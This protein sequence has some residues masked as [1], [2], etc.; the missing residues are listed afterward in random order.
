MGHILDSFG[1]NIFTKLIFLA[2]AT[3]STTSLEEGS[4]DRYTSNLIYVKKGQ[5]LAV[6]PEWGPN[7]RITFDLNVHSLYSSRSDG[8]ANVLYFTAS[9]KDCC[10]IGDRVPGLWTNSKGN[11]LYFCNNVDHN[12]DYCRTT[13]AGA[14]RTNTWC[15]K[16][17]KDTSGGTLSK[18]QE[19]E[20]WP[21]SLI[22]NPEN[23]TML[24]F[25]QIALFI[26]LRMPKSEI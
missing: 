22:Q 19:L 26:L 15:N 10:S 6:I 25:M 24:L 20:Q 5:L 16:S 3:F 11:Y 9:G 14:F 12:G 1:M 13:A 18:L 8:W 21:M 17:L 4:E 2:G 23:G 7:F